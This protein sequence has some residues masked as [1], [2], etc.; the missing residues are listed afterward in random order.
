MV[1]EQ[2]LRCGNLYF[3]FVEK[4]NGEIVVGVIMGMSKLFKQINIGQE[5]SIYLDSLPF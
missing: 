2:E 3:A 1:L 5:L 4:Q